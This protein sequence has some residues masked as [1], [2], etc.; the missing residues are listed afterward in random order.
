[1]NTPLVTVYVPCANY[2]RFLVQAVESVFAQSLGQWELFIIDDGST[3]ET[4][5]IAR[6]LAAGRDNVRVFTNDQPR[7]LA[8]NANLALGEARGKYLIRLDADDWL[9]ESCLLVLADHLDK[10]PD[11]ALVY[12]NYFYVD[13]D[14]TVLGV[15]QRKR[16]GSEVELLDLPAHGAC[17][18]VRK[19]AIKT[20]GGYDERP[21]AQDGWDIWL[22]LLHRHKVANVATPLFCYRQHGA[23]L[24]RDESRLLAAR[25][26]IKKTYVERHASSGPVKPRTLAV[27]PAK[28][29]YPRLPN[30]VLESVAGRPLIEYTL[31]AAIDARCDLI[32][33]TT[34]DDE[35]VDYLR[36]KHPSVLC[37]R[38]PAELSK[39]ERRLSEVTFDAV[40]QSESIA[41]HH[42]DII[43]SLSVHSPLRNHEDVE[44]AVHA[45]IA[46]NS[47]TVISVYEDHDL[48]LIHGAK[49]MCPLNPGMERKLRLEREGLYVDNGAITV[50]WRECLTPGTRLTGRVAH[51]VMPQHRSLQ[52]KSELDRWV[53]GQLIQHLAHAKESI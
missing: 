27:I 29:S 41:S 39:T 37:L 9:D 34:D 3:D 13:E 1:M 23:S 28:N 32:V 2:A 26:Q 14:G 6:E 20:V 17:T 33:V 52:I 43:V 40:M 47:D 35:V 25:G 12:P 51:T 46:F 4:P 18:M 8:Y 53:A 21:R 30:V 36:S 48:H 24:S 44:R 5:T 31:D 22:K 16:V 49:G 19:R 10:H 45:L 50:T 42:A 38:R 15:E 7:G 11:V